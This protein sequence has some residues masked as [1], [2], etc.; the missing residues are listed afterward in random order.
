MKQLVAAIESISGDKTQYNS[1][2]SFKRP[3]GVTN[4]LLRKTLAQR[5]WE[6]DTDILLNRQRVKPN[7]PELYTC[8]V[9][10]MMHAVKD[11][12]EFVGYTD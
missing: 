6:P 10:E 1:Y 12:G 2:R 11:K 8:R 4:Q 9:C 3:G 5:E 7:F